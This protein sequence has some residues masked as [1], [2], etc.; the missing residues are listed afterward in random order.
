MGPRSGKIPEEK[1]DGSS[2]SM[3][4]SGKTPEED[5][6]GSSS[7]MPR[8]GKIPEEEYDGSSSS[9]PRSGKIPEEEYSSS[10]SPCIGNVLQWPHMR[11]FLISLAM[12]WQCPAVAPHENVPH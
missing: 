3:P 9:M 1:Y 12:H 2:Y 5:I 10:S 6:D 8:S 7:S 11:M 4:R